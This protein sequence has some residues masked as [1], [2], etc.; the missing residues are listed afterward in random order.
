MN[1]RIEVAIF[2]PEPTFK[3]TIDEIK[4]DR[5]KSITCIDMNASSITLKKPS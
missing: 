4:D 2:E 3:K 5:L 1:R